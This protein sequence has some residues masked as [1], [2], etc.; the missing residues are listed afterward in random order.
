MNY[1]EKYLKYKLK[2]VDLKNKLQGGKKPKNKSS[3]KK[4]KNKSSGKKPKKNSSG[5]KP[6][7]KSSGKKPRKYMMIEKINSKE[8]KNRDRN[9]EDEMDIYI[10]VKYNNE[11]ENKTILFS[12]RDKIQKIK[13]KLFSIRNVY[14]FRRRKEKKRKFNGIVVTINKLDNIVEEL[15]DKE[16][17]PEQIKDSIYKDLL[18][19][20]DEDLKNVEYDSVY[21]TQINKEGKDQCI[22]ES[23]KKTAQFC[24]TNIEDEC[25]AER[26]SIDHCIQNCVIP[27]K[28][29]KTKFIYDVTG[30]VCM[31]DGKKDKNF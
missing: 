5:K 7:N 16:L 26:V 13:P 17:K 22:K 6:K 30:D 15:L 25:F 14:L 3:G 18:V 1:K 20:D 11:E 4:P 23:V 24:D 27:N 9:T 10:S 2:Y 28:G 29:K 31:V 19:S 12:L 21:L 8:E